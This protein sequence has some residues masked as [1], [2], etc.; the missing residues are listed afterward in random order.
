MMVPAPRLLKTVALAGLPLSLLAAA[1]PGWTIFCLLAGLAVI[2]IVITDA[3]RASQSWQGLELCGPPMTRLA[4]DRPGKLEIKLRHS[5]ATERRVRLALPWPEEL[6]AHPEE[7]SLMLPPG[8]AW[9]LGEWTLCP[10]RRG[11]YLI[12]T[13]G[14]E[15][16]SPWGFWRVRRQQPL[17]LEIRVYPNLA[18]ERTPLASLFLRRGMVG[19]HAVRQVGK[20]REFE[21]LR[22]YLPGDSYEDVHWKATARRARP[23]TKVYQ[24][25]KTQEIYVLLDASRLSGRPAAR[26]L[27]MGAAAD[28]PTAHIETAFERY[29]TAA[30]VL[31]LAAEQQGDHFG[32]L[33]FSDK[34][35]RFVRARNGRHHYQTCRDALYTLMPQEVAPDFDEV[36]TFLRLRLRRRALLIFLTSLED[37]LM[38]ESFSRNLEMLCR[39]HLILVAMLRPPLALPIFSSA[40]AQNVDDLYLHLAGHLQWWK[41]QELERSLARRGVRLTL[42]DQEEL[43]AGLVSQYLT[44]KRRQLL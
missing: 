35:E 43:S 25:E 3:L 15:T 41:L 10:H 17:R 4:K 27:Q 32:L 37:P 38:A 20:G 23:I 29:L 19:V 9:C 22:E 12:H 36:A 33:S 21:L 13:A 30:L 28:T 40:E 5:D 8:Q 11:R 34:I 31:G 39:Q 18:R 16:D 26:T 7:L 44:I 1:A 42:L 2:A 24:I 14:V 6:T